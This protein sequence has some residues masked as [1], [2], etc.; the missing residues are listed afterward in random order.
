MTEG[1]GSAASGRRPYDALLGLGS[2]IGDKAANIR[3]ALA[4]LTADGAIT[5]IRLSH[6]YRSP[7]W[8]VTD[9]EGFVNVCAAVATDLPPH[10]LLGRCLGAEEALGRQRTLKWGPRV[11]DVD[12]L[13]YRDETIDTPSL[14]VPHPFIEQRGFVLVPLAEIA[15]E[16]LVRGVKVGELATRA[17]TR[18]VVPL[19]SEFS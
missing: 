4:F 3:A 12:I 7:P 15:P 2:N 6:F 10:E 11:V 9:Q 8:G 14:Q 1:S 18:D 16:A 17:D 13:T 5:L 19:G